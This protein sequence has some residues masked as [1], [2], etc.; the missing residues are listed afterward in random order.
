VIRRRL[1]LFPWICWLS[2]KRWKLTVAKE[3]EY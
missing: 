1:I 2:E 3:P